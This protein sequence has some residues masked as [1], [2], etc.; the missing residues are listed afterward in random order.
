MPSDFWG[1]AHSKYN[2]LWPSFFW[3][4][5]GWWVEKDV[6]QGG[7][8]LLLQ[9]KTKLK[10][11]KLRFI[12]ILKVGM[13]TYELTWKQNR[14]IDVKNQ[15]CFMVSPCHHFLLCEGQLEPLLL[16]LPSTVP[17]T[18]LHSSFCQNQN[19]R[20]SHITCQQTQFLVGLSWDALWY[21]HN[22]GVERDAKIHRGHFNQEGPWWYDTL[23]RKMVFST[24]L[25]LL[26]N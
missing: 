11:I 7:S 23:E 21:N 15:V 18:Q 26:E 2:N 17:E 14:K 1:L 5:R 20:L 4:Q 25:L 16:S 19:S 8:R 24:F 6:W 3:R 22:S 13:S 9:H 10:L 12:Q